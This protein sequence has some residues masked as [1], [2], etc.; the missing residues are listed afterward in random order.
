MDPSSQATRSH[1][2]L[3]CQTWFAWAPSPCLAS[4]GRA[5]LVAPLTWAPQARVLL[6]GDPLIVALGRRST[7]AGQ[8]GQPPRHRR[9]SLPH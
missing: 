6:L 1:T 4:R 8:V 5:G 3:L 2:G 9:F 7:P